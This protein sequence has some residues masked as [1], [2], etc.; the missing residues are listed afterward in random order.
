MQRRWQFTRG[1]NGSDLTGKIMVFRS[2][3]AY[4]W[5][6]RI[7]VWLYVLCQE[8]DSVRTCRTPTDHLRVLSSLTVLSR[9]LTASSNF[10]FSVIC[11]WHSSSIDFFSELASFKR[12][13]TSRRLWENACMWNKKKIYRKCITYFSF[14]LRNKIGHCYQNIKHD[15]IRNEP[16]WYHTNTAS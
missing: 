3:V 9:S 4:V 1:S 10:V 2:V 7:E 13:S 14:F 8:K 6:S 15:G 12:S 5:G 11:F 16:L